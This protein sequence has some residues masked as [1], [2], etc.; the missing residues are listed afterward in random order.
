MKIKEKNEEYYKEH[1]GFLI[2][3]VPSYSLYEINK[4]FSEDLLV[5]GHLILI[6]GLNTDDTTFLSDYKIDSTRYYEEQKHLTN[7]YI[8]AMISD[9]DRTSDP[10]FNFIRTLMEKELIDIYKRQKCLLPPTYF[11]AGVCAPGMRR[12]FV[13][14]EGTFYM[15]ERV[16]Y[17]LP[18]GDIDNGIEIT[19]VRNIISDYIILFDENCANCWSLCL[20]KHCFSSARKGEN[21]SMD[22]RKEICEIQKNSIHNNLVLYMTIL[23][24]NPQSFDYM[25]EIKI[26]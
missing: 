13:S 9:K 5:R 14:P 16:G 15:C 24:K 18:I 26:S 2:T 1:I 10:D 7:T 21:L 3:L 19:K 8:K 11:P 4:F 17:H 6:S 22:K 25:K 20:C 12:L 23:E